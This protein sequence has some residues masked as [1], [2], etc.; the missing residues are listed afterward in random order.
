MRE[1]HAGHE[2]H[3]AKT[4]MGQVMFL[5]VSNQFFNGVESGK[6]FHPLWTPN[7]GRSVL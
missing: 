1:R 3:D 6:T 7:G 5:R 4:A 2:F